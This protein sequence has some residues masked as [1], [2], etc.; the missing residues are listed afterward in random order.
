MDVVARAGGRS[1]RRPGAWRFIHFIFG[2][3]HDLRSYPN[4]LFQRR[5]GRKRIVAPDGSELAPSS[6]PQPDGTLEGAGAGLALAA[7]AR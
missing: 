7:D 4:A 1:E 2:R 3:Q 6:K 5:G